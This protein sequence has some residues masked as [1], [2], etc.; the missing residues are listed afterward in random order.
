[1]LSKS[2]FYLKVFFGGLLSG[3]SISFSYLIPVYF[4][5]YYVLIKGLLNNQDYTTSC[6]S[7]WCFGAGFFLSSMHWIVNPFLV[8]DEHFF[9][10]PFIFILFPT[11]MA[12]FYS[13]SCIL[14]RFFLNKFNNHQ[15]LLFMN[16]FVISL[17][18]F[19]SEYLR[20][21]I[22]GG[23]P[24]NLAAHIWVF[25]NRLIKIVS[26]FGVFGLS[27]LT[28]YWITLLSLLLIKKKFKYFVIS[29]F[30]LPTFLFFFPISG[31]PNLS[32]QTQTVSVRIIQPNIPQKEKWKKSY[33]E[34]HI[35]NL[36]G[37]SKKK[38]PEDELLVIWPEV[39]LTVYLN[40][41]NNLLEYIKSNLDKNTT[42]I[43]G[44]LRR[45]FTGKNFEIYNSLYVIQNNTVNFYDKRRLVPFGEFIPL[46]SL[47]NFLK[48]TPGQTD[49][50]EG[51]KSNF[52]TITF[53]NK[54]IGFEPS[55][56][57]EAIFQSFNHNKI[58]LIINITNDA[59]FG[60]TTGPIQHLT[61]S[62]FR[63][64]E[65]G[66]PLVRS[67]NSGIS[68]ITDANGKTL[69]RIELNERGI[70]QR[71]ILLR[72]NSTF[73]VE[74]GNKTVLMMLI[75]IFIVSFLIDLIIKKRKSLK[76]I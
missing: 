75:F 43:T 61:A 67:A 59:W 18:L 16:S 2:K 19:F 56:C 48:L 41:Q 73:F 13:V 64:V 9:L 28:T 5:G 38:N 29:I 27:I 42:L 4:I 20:S 22:F 26:F 14:I 7:G 52:L 51:N 35:E 60:N 65:K 15:H 46:R 12:I 58:M 23:L 24:F 32:N 31:A 62:I 25:D 76:N 40:E 63:S 17:M 47:F 71:D 69:E 66:V 37:L 10:V 53:N 72:K 34:K 36:I 74:Y 54:I 11:V 70:I 30:S 33:F 45:N 55:I 6:I 21:F 44:G 49:F 8:Y 57:Y 39:A 68:T 3:I 1:M 50:S